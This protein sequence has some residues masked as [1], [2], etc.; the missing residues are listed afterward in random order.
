MWDLLEKIKYFIGEYILPISILIWLIMVWY[1][2]ILF[3]IEE[4]F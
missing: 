3:V 4:L 1:M 2:V